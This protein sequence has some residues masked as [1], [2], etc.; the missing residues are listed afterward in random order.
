MP[1]NII[2]KP[3]CVV[4]GTAL[5]ID[6]IGVLILGPPHS[7]KSEL[8]FALLERGHCLIADDAVT[9]EPD[10]ESIFATPT[11][12]HNT[13]IFLRSL[14]IIDPQLYFQHQTHTS[15]GKINL[16]IKLCPCNGTIPTYQLNPKHT[17]TYLGVNI[18]YWTLYTPSPIDL[19]LKVET[20]VKKY[21]IEIALQN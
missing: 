11:E 6:K 21:K 10:N 2:T 20:V 4:H 15:H 14:G 1:E 12:T 19:A 17:T 3:S 16:I 9:L 7:G 18:P 8:A 13:S 5:V